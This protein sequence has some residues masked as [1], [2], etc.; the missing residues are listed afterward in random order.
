[1][2]AT[3]FGYTWWD[4]EMD[5]EHMWPAEQR[6]PSAAEQN[7]I[8][9]RNPERSAVRGLWSDVGFPGENR[10]ARVQPATPAHTV[11]RLPQSRLDFPRRLQARSQGQPARRGRQDSLVRRSRQI[12]KGR[13]PQ[14]H[15]SGKGHALHRLPLRAGQPR[16]WQALRRNAQRHRDRLRR[17]PRHDSAARHADHLRHRRA[18]RR[19]QPGAACARR[20]R[21][22]VST[23]KTTAS[24]SAPCW[25]KTKNGKS[26]R[27]WTRSRP[28]TQH[29]SEKSRLAKTIQQDGQTWGDAPTKIQKNQNSR[30]RTAR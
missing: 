12:R 17:L 9:T 1:M 30:T 13:A 14:R 7:R 22:A 27:C 19:H 23:G 10:H 2:V 4:N 18:R 15:P 20:G 29:Y 8:Q 3:Y 21:S 28:A 11:C 5:G 24:I 25:R 26:C 6:N 16:Q